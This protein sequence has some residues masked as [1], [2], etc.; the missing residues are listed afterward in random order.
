MVLATVPAAPPTW[1]NQRATSWPAPISAKVPYRFASRLIWSA[2]WLVST[3]S[4]F[5]SFGFP[6]VAAPRYQDTYGGGGYPERRPTWIGKERKSAF[7]QPPF[8]SHPGAA[9]AAVR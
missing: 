6:H 9:L 2:F 5:M 7:G 8:R 3:F 1:K 4:S